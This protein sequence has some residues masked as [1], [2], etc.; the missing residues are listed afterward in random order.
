M[1]ETAWTRSGVSG[2]SIGYEY[3]D[4]GSQVSESIVVGAVDRRGRRDCE[5]NRE[6]VRAWNGSED[7]SGREAAA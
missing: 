4:R 3:F 1:R 7:A 6:G 5:D 2:I